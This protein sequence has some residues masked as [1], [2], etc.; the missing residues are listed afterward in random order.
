MLNKSAME[1]V[2]KAKQKIENL[3][4]DQVNEQFSTGTVN[5]IDIRESDEM[6]LSGRIAGSVHVPRGLLE[7]YADPSLVY[8]KPEFDETKKIILYCSTGWRSSLAVAALKKMGYRNVAHLDG[9]IKAWKDAGKPV[10]E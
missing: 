10:I 3:S 7:F 6:K 8:Y 5:L 2:K 4:P 9:G 1:L